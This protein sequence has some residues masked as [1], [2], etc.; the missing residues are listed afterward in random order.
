M[1]SVSA[2]AVC[3]SALPRAHDA[4]RDL[5]LLVLS[6][7]SSSAQCVG[8][9]LRLPRAQALAMALLYHGLNIACA[10]PASF[11]ARSTTRVV[12][13]V[14]QRASCGDRFAVSV[15]VTPTQ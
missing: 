4:C 8:A 13:P 3:L 15:S 7:W 12:W 9:R 5:A 14:R 1:A 6:A 10:H 11:T 2:P